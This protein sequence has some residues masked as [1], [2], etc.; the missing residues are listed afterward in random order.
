MLLLHLNV[1]LLWYFAAFLKVNCF[2]TTDCKCKV[3]CLQGNGP[4]FF[5]FFCC[6]P[7]CHGS[8]IFCEALGFVVSRAVAVE[9]CA[10]CSG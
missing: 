5:F 1:P 7:H 4:L 3:H 9:R 2:M 10:R 8:V 6:S